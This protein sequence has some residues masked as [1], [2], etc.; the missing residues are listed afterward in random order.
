MMVQP[1]P[2][3]PVRPLPELLDALRRHG[4]RRGVEPSGPMPARPALP[5]GQPDLDRALGTGGWPRGAL[6]LIDAPT[7]SGA[8]SLAL[9]TLAA[10]QASG[11]LVAY[12]DPAGSL[13]PA[14]AS[15]LG[16]DLAWLLVVRPADA[17]EA[18]ELA[19]WLAREGRIDA[20]VLD[21]ADT[22]L[23][24]GLD[25]LADLLVRSGGVTLLLA[26]TGREV[27][28]RVAGVRVALQR[29]AWLAVG[30]DLVGQRV[31]ATVTR[32][33]W[34]LAGSRA[35]LDLYFAE[36]RRTDALLRTSA[37]PLAEPAASDATL[38]VP[39]LQVVGA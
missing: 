32:Q 1:D 39:S 36:G 37:H 30:R 22:F 17:A 9:G 13:D 28:G 5:T 21:L 14:T 3:R 19:G 20:M 34:A 27:A 10:C 4:L 2:P 11:G 8:T 16:I 6:A 23:P 26:G 38:E 25:R 7:G 29:R 12:L 18:V 15:W 33:R 24:R 31:E 35:Q